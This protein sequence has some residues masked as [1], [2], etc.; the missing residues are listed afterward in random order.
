MKWTVIWKDIGYPIPL[1]FF[2]PILYSQQLTLSNCWL[3]Y[4]SEVILIAAML[5]NFEFV[6][7]NQAEKDLMLPFTDF[8]P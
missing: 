8:S 1:S 2:F 5:H 4:T 7:S 3:I 6:R